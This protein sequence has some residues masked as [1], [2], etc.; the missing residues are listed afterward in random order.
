MPTAELPLPG[1]NGVAPLL[2]TYRLQLNREFDFDAALG[3]LPYLATLGVSHVYCSPIL[4]AQPGSTHGYDVVDP[5]RVDPALGGEAGFERLAEA[6]HAA[7]LGIMVDIVPNHMGI[8]GPAN[9]WWDDVLRQ[10]PASPHA[11][12]FD[13]D[14]D[15]DPGRRLRLPILGASVDEAREAG[16]FELRRNPGGDWRLRYHEHDLPVAPAG[17]EALERHAGSTAREGVLREAGA[18]EALLEAQHYRLLHWTEAARSINYRRFFEVSTLAG[19]RAEDPEVFEATHGC[20]LSL[21][22]RGLV[23]ALRIDHPDGLRDP[24]S[25]FHRLQAA[26]AE[27]RPEAAPFYIAAEKIL[28]PGES[29]PP[30]W[31]IAGTTGYDF[32]NEV[33]G[34]MVDGDQ[35]PALDAAW[36]EFTGDTATTFADVARAARREVLL[37]AFGSELRRLVGLALGA[38]A[39]EEPGVWPAL[40]EL[41]A[42]FPV[43]RSYRVPDEPPSEADRQAIEHACRVARAQLE[44]HGGEQREQAL[45]SLDSLAAALL[46]T[47]AHAAGWEFIARFQQ[48]TAPVAAKGVEDTAIYRFPRIASVNGVG[49]DP[50]LVGLSVDRFHQACE[51]RLAQWP[52]A[53]LATSTH[54]NKRSEDVTM[55]IDALSEAPGPW[56]AIATAWRDAMRLAADPPRDDAGPLPPVNPG[57]LYL[58]MQTALGAWPIPRPASSEAPPAASGRQAFAARLVAY[59]TKAC[60]EAKRETRWTA[61]DPRYEAAIAAAVHRLLD[62]ADGEPARLAARLRWHGGIASLSMT[63]LKA[64][65]PGIPDIYRGAELIDDSLVDPDNR[66]PVDFSRR[67]SLLDEMA[68][69]DADAIEASLADWWREHDFDRLK[70]WCLHR[71]LAARRREPLLFARGD[72]VPVVVRGPRA[73]HLVAFARR[74]ADAGGERLL[75]V[76]AARLPMGLGLEPGRRADEASLWDETSLDV[77]GAA[78]PL[79]SWRDLLD[80]REVRI[81]DGLAPIPGLLGGLPCAVLLGGSGAFVA[82]TRAQHEPRADGETGAASP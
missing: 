64:S 52:D 77:A 53:M 23:D 73:R 59:M 25:Y 71:L 80:G 32:A 19:I 16:H 5:A 34:L 46:G 43:Y 6:A 13:I 76:L 58:L 33:A 56:S 82:S 21:V 35:V 28:A 40:V 10:G 1:A 70:L 8:A 29:L 37:D 18:L 4:A 66:R 36:R 11:P 60:R 41:I 81:E 17:I 68:R 65:V 50:D 22:E 7:G 15:A 38:G 9:G 51:R 39:G 27:R 79:G 78:L 26:I 44:A 69:L 63:V 30:D 14:W 74:L 42:A 55:R 3:L 31:P 72:Y 12:V 57:D 61:P 20:I 2:A 49:G 54:D 75:L 47:P 62:A 45:A 67:R 24:A 48:L